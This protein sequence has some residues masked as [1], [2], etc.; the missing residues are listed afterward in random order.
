MT[1]LSCLLIALLCA[2]PALSQDAD[3]VQQAARLQS[4]RKYSEAIALALGAARAAKLPARHRYRAFRIAAECYEQIGCPREAIA[5]LQDA[6]KALGADSEYAGDLWYRLA[7]IHSSRMGATDTA[8][9][10]ESAI[11]EMDFP[12]MTPSAA[13]RV[14]VALSTARIGLGQYRAALG[15]AEQA[16][17]QARREPK[18]PLLAQATVALAGAHMRLR[19]L[20]A[21][22]ECLEGLDGK[23]TDRY[24]APSVAAAAEELVRG[25]MGAG[26]LTD[27]RR[28]GLKL[29]ALVAPY[30]VL[31][32]RGILRRLLEAPAAE[33]LA[34]LATLD[35][36]TVNAI[37]S[38][39]VLPKL[40]PVAMASDQGDVLVRLCV[41][42]MLASLLSEEDA[43]AC[44]ATL[45]AVRLQQGRLDDAL[46][47]AW[48]SYSVAG[49]DDRKATAFTHAVGLL[50]HALR[51]RDGH[52]AGANAFRRYQTYGPHGPDRRAD[53]AD[54]IPNPLKGAGFRA[55][56]ELDALFEAALK[57]Q[58]PTYEGRR[59]RAWIYLLWCKPAKAL[60]E[61]KQ[62][63]ALCSLE[64][65]AMAQA[66]QEV[67]MGLKALHA[68][69]VGMDAF[70]SYQR[71]GPHGPDG[72]AGTADDLKDPLA[73]F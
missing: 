47:A 51:A 72:R 17:A 18:G 43:R 23:L 15:A 7:Y 50:S 58:P 35:D 31:L 11:A 54:D 13:C 24:A 6:L 52:L 3:A 73:G 53:T 56:P 32:A 34:A 2:A 33:T 12:K 62:A 46:A 39:E 59:R 61:Y 67:A 21:A 14:L 19:Q 42:A 10:L 37:A 57:A 9:F 49:F 44:L 55:D 65:T 22:R 25:L 38:D 5:T 64:P 68:T 40:V 30:D 36:K 66:A 8:L 16:V 1:R 29:A 26:R 4:G 69:T 20:D 70:A 63:F 45:V 71:H 60:S 27:A 28:A 41:R 48:A